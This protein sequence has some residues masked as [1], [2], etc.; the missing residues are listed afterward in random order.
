M[1]PF[2]AMALLA[3]PALAACSG[4]DITLHDFQSVGG[5]PEEFA[6]L[7]SKPLEQPASY[8]ALPAPTP[9][10]RNRTD[11]TP[12]E[13][14]VAALGG[15]PSQLALTGVPSSEGGLVNYASR[16]GRDP[17]IRQVLAQEDEE[18]RRR[19]S[20]LTKIRLFRVD[21][22]Y[23]SYEGQSLDGES[24]AWGWRRAGAPT[25]TNPPSN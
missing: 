2:R 13:D 10:G 6:V 11:L 7:P 15:R 16:Q 24:T 20:F 4:R 14:A 25:P 12:K 8:N 23:Q 21:R 19:K 1:K 9:G 17:A 22:Y 18:F 3:L 5:G